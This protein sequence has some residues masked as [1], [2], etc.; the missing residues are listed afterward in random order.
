MDFLLYEAE[1]LLLS[2]LETA[3]DYKTL[4]VLLFLHIPRDLFPYQFQNTQNIFHTTRIDPHRRS[5]IKYSQAFC[6]GTLVLILFAAGGSIA[7]R[8]VQHAYK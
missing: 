6:L 4:P 8:C 2:A 1:L 7:V 5:S 3:S